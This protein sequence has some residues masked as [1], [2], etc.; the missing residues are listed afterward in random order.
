MYWLEQ[1]L[2]VQEVVTRP[3]IESNYLIQLNSC[4]L[5]L[6]C[7]VNEFYSILAEIRNYE[8][9]L[10]ILIQ[11]KLNF[12]LKVY[13]RWG[14]LY[15]PKDRYLVKVNS[16]VNKRLF[17]NFPWGQ[18]SYYYSIQSLLNFLY[19]ILYDNCLYNVLCMI[20]LL[21]FI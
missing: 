2:Y 18:V 3:K 12:C 13:G 21:I 19:Y 7:S 10:I 14:T 1:L 16:Q 4:G 11:F 15:T 20:L 6:F 17:C 9:Y 5:K 8:I